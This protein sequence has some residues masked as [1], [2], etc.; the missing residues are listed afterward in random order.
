MLA[1]IIK[2]ITYYKYITYNK[3]NKKNI[4]RTLIYNLY[5][6]TMVLFYFINKIIQ[7]YRIIKLYDI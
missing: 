4:Y 6:N 2:I 3:N 1:I 5:C 7:S